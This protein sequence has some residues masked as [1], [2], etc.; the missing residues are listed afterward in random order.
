[1]AKSKDAPTHSR[2]SNS[3]SERYSAIQ[4]L[5]VKYFDDDDDWLACVSKATEEV[6]AK[7]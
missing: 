3:E 4:I 7:D 5:A 2:F 6:D 1:M